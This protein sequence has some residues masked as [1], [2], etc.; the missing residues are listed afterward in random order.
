MVGGF[1]FNEIDMNARMSVVVAPEQFG[2]EA[3]CKGGK[4][5]DFD[6]P[7]LGASDRSYFL[8]ALADLSERLAYSTQ[9]ALARQGWA[10]TVRAPQK[11]RGANLVFE[12]SNT[13]AY[14]RLLHLKCGGGLS[15]TAMLCCRDDKPKMLYIWL[16]Q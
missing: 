5:A 14:H 1:S 10:D 3:G 7:T 16:K 6:M 8:R 9:E 11:E 13:A 4:Q 12:V 15:K 2:Q